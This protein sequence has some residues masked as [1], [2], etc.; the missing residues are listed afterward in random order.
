MIAE[1]DD[2][3]LNDESLTDEDRVD[4]DESAHV[5]QESQELTENDESSGSYDGKQYYQWFMQ[6]RAKYVFRLAQQGGRKADEVRDP[7]GYQ[8]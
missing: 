5:G 1:S 7:V 2:S 3:F 6:S 4:G 8:S